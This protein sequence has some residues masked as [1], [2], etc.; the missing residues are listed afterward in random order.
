MTIEAIISEKISVQNFQRPFLTMTKAAMEETRI[1]RTV[2]EQVMMKELVNTVQNFIFFMASGKFFSVKP[3]APTS[4]SGL[5]TISALLL[6]TLIMTI[7][8]GKTKQKNIR[9]RKIHMRACEIFCRRAAFSLSAISVIMLRPL[10][11]YQP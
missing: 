10:L 11:S 3:W 1:V 2:A 9:S 7:K 8:K 6:K 4:A 5:E